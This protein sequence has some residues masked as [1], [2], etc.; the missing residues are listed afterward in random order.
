[1]FKKSYIIVVLAL[2]SV[3]LFC[4]N[5]SITLESDQKMI[6]RKIC[7]MLM[8]LHVSSKKID[9]KFSQ[10]VFK[11][12]LEALDPYKRY[13]KKSD[14]DHFKQHENKIDDYFISGSF[15]FYNVTLNRYLHRVNESEKIVYNILNHPIKLDVDE[16]LNL[17]CK[18]RK[19]APNNQVYFHE[20][21]KFLKRCILIELV[22]ISQ[23]KNIHD[24]INVSHDHEY[25][26]NNRYD[27]FIKNP[28][29]INYL[30]FKQLKDSA[31]LSVKEIMKD[32]FRKIKLRNKKDYF[33]IY[34]N[35]FTETFDPHTMYFAPKEA[36]QFHSNMSGK[37]IGIG[38]KLQ[39]VKGYPVVKEIITG[40]PAWKSKDIEVGD[41]L[42][43]I[44]EDINKL[45]NVVGLLLE[46]IISLI[47][48]KENSKVFV[49]IE[50]KDGSIKTFSVIRKAI[51]LED[52][53]IKSVIIKN[54]KNEKF[55][56]IY[57]PEFYIDL[58]NPNTGRRSG[59]DFKKEILELKKE[60]IQGLIVDLRGNGGGALSEVVKIV[61]QFIKTGPIV[62]V[63]RS[64][65]EEQIYEDKDVS[66]LYDGSLLVIVDEF[67]ASA[68]EIFAAA[69]QDYKRGIIVG[70]YQTFG[71]GTVQTVIPLD[72]FGISLET[73]GFLKLTI[74]KFY[75]V[76]GSST[77]IKGV[78]PD[79][80]LGSLYSNL[81]VLERNQKNALSWD[82]VMPSHYIPWHRPINYNFVKHKSKNRMQNHPFLQNIQEKAKWLKV[83]FEDYNISLNYKK[84]QEQ[85]NLK[86]DINT[87]YQ[88]ALDYRN[89]LHFI[90]PKY[91]VLK[92][93]NNIPLKYNRNKWYDMLV[94]DFY[95]NESVAIL[96]DMNA[97]T[98]K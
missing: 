95:L 33:S 87:K 3:F 40:G 34:L 55:G 15:D 74:Q 80:V 53:F 91:E 21:K 97:S 24:N 19:Y 76:N 38:V 89:Q 50:K 84:F 28:K 31:V 61:G 69:I 63:R 93:K 82:S 41:K 77:Q 26:L 75:R 23:G 88:K 47:R 70:S 12:Y 57:L 98:L 90:P 96:S 11:K 73:N 18:S 59:E 56:L 72:Q 78:R 32:Y 7:H 14:F 83:I 4:F 65:G 58:Q 62:K 81:N 66:V 68:S 86:K 54:H 67:S 46:D 8:E 36:G 60:N 27:T 43:K 52:H 51:E 79:I 35:S 92:I 71:K 6:L 39:D 9:D 20:W 49:V 13:F 25:F 48:G 1:M 45:H 94:K 85:F 10:E 30:S 17:D 16:Y 22:R 64:D 42:L 2:L 29:E 37:I 5:T 44:G